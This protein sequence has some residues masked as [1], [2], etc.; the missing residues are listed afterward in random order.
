MNKTIA[1]DGTV[2]LA[3][4]VA[5]RTA[6]AR[7]YSHH[8]GFELLY[9]APEVGW[10]EMS[11]PIQGLTIGLGD[12]EGVRIGGPVPTLGIDD[13]DHS[14]SLLEGAGVRFDGPTI[15]HEGMVKI[16]TFYDP[17]GHAWMLAQNLAES[18]PVPEES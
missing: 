9:D 15:V 6:S 12:S 13:M 5:D 16:A 14:R 1:Y 4:G 3:L 18:A 10:C 8:L 17:D 11:S 7:W 2:T